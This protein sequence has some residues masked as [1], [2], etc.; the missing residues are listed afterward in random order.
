[1]FT[2]SNVWVLSKKTSSVPYPSV[3]LAENN[4]LLPS[5][6]HDICDFT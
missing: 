1:M 5:G 2:I 6:D 4:N 3:S